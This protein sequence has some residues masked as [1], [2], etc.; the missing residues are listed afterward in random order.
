MAHLAERRQRFA[1]DPLGRRL[2]SDQLGVFGLQGL[3]FAEKPVVLRIGNRR[4]VEH[5]VAVVVGVDLAA[6]GGKTFGG[7]LGVGH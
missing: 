2:G 1:T 6:Q 4:L 3:E 5:V 7:G